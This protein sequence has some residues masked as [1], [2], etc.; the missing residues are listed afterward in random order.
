MQMMA[1][2]L[3][4]VNIGVIVAPLAGVAIIYRDNLSELVVPPEVTQLI[5]DTSINGSQIQLP[6]FVDYTYDAAAKT[7]TVIFNFTNPLNL[8]VT[9]NSLSADV[10]C[11]EHGLSLG[12]VGIVNPVELDR[13]ITAYILVVFS[14]TAE[15]ENHFMAE[16]AGQDAIS[17]SLT[18]IVV[19]ISGITVEAPA[20][21]DIGN[22]PI[23]QV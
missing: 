19:D 20:S 10:V 12:H 16:H 1:L 18:N 7:V 3:I 17:I 14:W 4:L 9:I 8:N 5:G 2:A 11:N 21:Y 13:G 22:I 23:P 15:A 6:Q